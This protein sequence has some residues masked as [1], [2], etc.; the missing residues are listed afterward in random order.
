MEKQ[1]CNIWYYTFV[2]NGNTLSK[3]W[4]TPPG[5]IWV[6]SKILRLVNSGSAMSCVQRKRSADCSLSDQVI[7][8]E[9]LFFSDGLG[10]FQ[11][12]H[13]RI[14]RAHIEALSMWVSYLSYQIC[15]RTIE[16][17]QDSVYSTQGKRISWIFRLCHSFSNR[18]EKEKRG[19]N[20]CLL[21][22]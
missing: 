22:C 10:I 15:F 8:S 14:H 17:N 7:L 12:D 16:R 21:T 1:K 20:S 13:A 11:D 18:H 9:D 6:C 3:Q 2:T 4:K 5:V 19:V